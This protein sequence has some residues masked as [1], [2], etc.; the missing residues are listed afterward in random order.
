MNIKKFFKRKKK[1]PTMYNALGVPIKPMPYPR[2]YKPIRHPLQ[3]PTTFTPKE[4]NELLP[5]ERK[6][7]YIGA[8]KKYQRKRRIERA[9]KESIKEKESKFLLP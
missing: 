9:L 4:T 3:R 2:T 8:R 1:E 7:R 5:F 6:R